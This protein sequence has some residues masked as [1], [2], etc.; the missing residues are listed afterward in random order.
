MV[1]EKVIAMKIY[2]SRG[3]KGSSVKGWDPIAIRAK[4][5]SYDPLIEF[6]QSARGAKFVVIPDDANLLSD[7]KTHSKTRRL[8][9][10]YTML[11]RNASSS[12]P[13]PRGSFWGQL[14]NDAA[15]SK[16]LLA[17]KSR[18]T[19][20]MTSELP[21]PSSSERTGLFW[22]QFKKTTPPVESLVTSLLQN[23]PTEQNIK[24]RLSSGTPQTQEQQKTILNFLQNGPLETKSDE[25]LETKS[26]EPAPFILQSRRKADKAVS[27]LESML[28]STSQQPVQSKERMTVSES[29]RPNSIQ[30]PNIESI[31]QTKKSNATP[32]KSPCSEIL[33]LIIDRV[34]KQNSTP[35]LAEIELAVHDFFVNADK[36]MEHKI[37]ISVQTQLKRQ[38]LKK[39]QKKPDEAE[40]EVDN[41]DEKPP[42]NPVERRLFYLRKETED[43]IDA[44]YNEAMAELDKTEKTDEDWETT[45]DLIEDGVEDVMI[46]A[47]APP[48]PIYLKNLAK[49][50]WSF[51]QGYSKVDVRAG[52][53]QLYSQW[54]D[55]RTQAEYEH[56]IKV[57]ANED[58]LGVYDELLNALDL[59]RPNES[60]NEL[61]S[62]LK[63]VAFK[64][65]QP[66]ASAARHRAR[67]LFALAND[68]PVPPK[69]ETDFK[70][71]PISD[72]DLKKE[73]GLKYPAWK[74]AT[75]AEEIKK[76]WQESSGLYPP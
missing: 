5:L 53:N 76:M 29:S 60:M 4:I 12:Q 25:P 75:I 9:E 11:K 38:E 7:E 55:A 39:D 37:A 52:I 45:L 36:N 65:R 16:P 1:N 61:F 42:S 34:S 13:Q 59:A 23:V 35:T 50:L 41:D 24:P 44:F 8:S 27:F 32:A 48:R 18:T 51:R 56:K 72:N 17:P 20:P 10:F 40:N 68:E 21:K 62:T 71:H 31:P 15:P 47:V 58:Q 6:A 63:Q 70:P 2:L 3:G 74:K 66:A 57:S 19:V 67:E 33:N 54:R 22:D 49:E 43:A 26:D 30:E 28:S 73:I 46:R 69:P 14:K 64:A